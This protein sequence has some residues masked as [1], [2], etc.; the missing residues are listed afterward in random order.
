MTRLKSLLGLFWAPQPYVWHLCFKEYTTVLIVCSDKPFNA[1]FKLLQRV[2]WHL[3][4]KWCYYTDLLAHWK[5]QLSVSLCKSNK[6]NVDAVEAIC[7]Q[8]CVC[9][10][11]WLLVHAVLV[12]LVSASASNPSLSN[13]S[14]LWSCRWCATLLRSHASWK[15]GATPATVA[16]CITA[17]GETNSNCRSAGHNTT[18][19][20][21]N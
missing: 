21:V 12:Y 7:W 4:V 3:V 9:V 17:R 13:L 1:Q 8:L 19:V 14:T 11:V 15:W 2:L 16:T 6:K 18:Q 5:Q 10:C 20:C